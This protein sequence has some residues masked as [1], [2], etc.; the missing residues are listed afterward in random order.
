MHVKSTEQQAQCATFSDAR[1]HL[2][3]LHMMNRER[4]VQLQVWLHAWRVWHEVWQ[5]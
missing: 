2:K 1:F 4:A 5:L 3:E